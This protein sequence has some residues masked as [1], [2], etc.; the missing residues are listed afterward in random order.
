M[1][2]RFVSKFLVVSVILLINGV[3]I[4]PVFASI[5][6]EIVHDEY[7]DVTTEFFGL[8]KKHTV[9]LTEAQMEELEILFES[10]KEKINKAETKEDTIKIY[11]EAIVELDRF[12]L[13]GDYNIKKIQ[14]LVYGEFQKK[15]FCSFIERMYNKIFTDNNFNIF[16]L[17]AGSTDN[18]VLYPPSITL[19]LIFYPLIYY[20][21]Q[22]P[23]MGFNIIFRLFFSWM[24]PLSLG[25]IFM[26]YRSN[27]RGHEENIPANGWINTL[28]LFGKKQIN[29]SFYGQIFL[30]LVPA[31][32][33]YLGVIGFK[34]ITIY[35]TSWPELNFLLGYSSYVNIG[36]NPPS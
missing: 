14:K 15:R 36:L 33:Y 35:N 1:K 27:N 5:Q 19:F 30:D 9:H 18:T 24:T 26:G 16:C 2:K 8:G 22:D 10:I 20:I 13:F 29:G 34:G 23:Y 7:F 12:G 6:F 28:G 31:D 21:F 3:G 4:Q 11:N 17:I 25:S 32:D